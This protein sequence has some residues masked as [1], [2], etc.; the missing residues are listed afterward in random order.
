MFQSLTSESCFVLLTG[1]LVEEFGMDSNSQFQ[2][3]HTTCMHAFDK[4]S[5]LDTA[6]TA[7]N[8]Q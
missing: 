7:T 1:P 6:S 2:Q 3:F 4:K 8:C 5:L